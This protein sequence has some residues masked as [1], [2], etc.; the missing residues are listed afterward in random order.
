MR[1][2]VCYFESYESIMEKMM[3]SS[4]LI[5]C[6]VYLGVACRD[7]IYL[8]D[9]LPTFFGQHDD[10]INVWKVLP[11][12]HRTHAFL[13]LSLS[14]SFVKSRM[15]CVVGI[16]THSP[17]PQRHRRNVLGTP[18]ERGGL[19]ESLHC[20]VSIHSCFHQVSAED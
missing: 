12:P 16:H 10:V 17:R 7:L 15:L 2:F 11:Y 9:S 4:H 19:L 13:T 8:H 5:L 3:F 14:F 20:D 18:W 1:L 6:A